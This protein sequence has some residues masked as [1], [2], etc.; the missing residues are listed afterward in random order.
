MCD[1]STPAGR[2]SVV[3]SR[4]QINRSRTSEQNQ[5]MRRNP[6]QQDGSAVAGKGPIGR[7]LL[8][9]LEEKPIVVPSVRIP[10]EQEAE[11]KLPR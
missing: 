9:V 10:A 7:V 3:S 1:G 5:V 4:T 11:A 6:E 2:E 8:R